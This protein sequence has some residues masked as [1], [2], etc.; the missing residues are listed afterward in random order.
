VNHFASFA[1]RRPVAF[2][3]AVTAAFLVAIV[4]TAAAGSRGGEKSIEIAGIAGRGAIA[5]AGVAFAMGAGWSS[6]ARVQWPE[7]A[8]QWA[9][10]LPPFLYC[11]VV[12]PLLFTGRWGVNLSDPGLSALVAGNGFAAG[13]CEE[14]IFRGVILCA[15]SRYGEGRIRPIVLSSVFFS[16][17]HALNIL[18]GAQPLRVLA[19]LGWAF[20]LGIGFAALVWKT[21]SVWPVG[22]MHG[23]LNAIV[24]LNA[25]HITVNL[26]LLRA[27]ATFPAA[28]P[29]MLYAIWLLQRSGDF[30]SDVQMR[31]GARRSRET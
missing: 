16:L 20:V 18:A 8:W 7:R 31:G 4:I 14:V 24:H 30:E 26:S 27:A 29:V 12:F 22:I 21:G 6:C 5:A 23:L 28:I 19:Q 15:L 25:L 10:M 11:G 9:I 1:V 2:S 13:V 3:A 17:P